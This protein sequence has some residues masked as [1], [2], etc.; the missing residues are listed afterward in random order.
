ME[1][2]RILRIKR[3]TCNTIE[4]LHIRKMIILLCRW[5]PPLFHR[6]QRTSIRQFKF[7]ANKINQFLYLRS[8]LSAHYPRSD[9]RV[10]Y[11]AMYSAKPST[12]T[13]GQNLKKHLD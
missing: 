9:G 1:E 3:R 13:D 10:R 2:W 11:L 7:Q 5:R 4:G 6:N 8:F 12:S